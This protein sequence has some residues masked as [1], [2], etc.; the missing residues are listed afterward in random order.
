[1]EGFA[2]EHGLAVEQASI[3]RRTVVLAGTVAQMSGAFRVDLGRYQVGESSY[4][5][6]EGHVHVPVGLAPLVEGVF[7][8]DDRQLIK[9]PPQRQ[10]DGGLVGEGI[11]PPYVAQLYNFPVGVNATG[12]CIGLLEFE[13]GY[14]WAD[15]H[16]WFDAL[17]LPRPTLVDVSVDG[18][19]NSPGINPGYDIGCIAD[20]DVA[21]SVA[22]R[23]RIAVYFAPSTEQGI[24]DAITTAINDGVNSPSVIVFPEGLAELYWSGDVVNAMHTA[25]AEAATM[26][27]NVLSSAGYMGSDCGVGNGLAHV[28]FPASDPLVLSCGGTTLNVSA[29][30]AEET[31]FSREYGASG[32]GV[33]DLFPLPAFQAS[34]G[35]PLSVNDFHSGRGVPDV[36]GNDDPASGYAFIMDGQPVGYVGGNTPTMYA[37]LLALI[38]EYLGQ[39]VGWLSPVLYQA[40]SLPGFRDITCCGTNAFAGVPGYSVGPGWDATTGLGRIDGTNLLQALPVQSMRQFL[41]NEQEQAQPGV[42]ATWTG[43]SNLSPPDDL[44]KVLA[45]AAHPDGRMHVVRA[46]LDNQLWHSEQ[47]QANPG[48]GASWTDWQPLTVP[49]DYALQVAM[50]AHP[51]SGRMHVVVADLDNVLW[52]IEQEQANPVAGASWTD[53]QLLK[54]YGDTA[55]QVAMAAHPDG[56]MHVVVAAPPPVTGFGLD[57]ALWHI[58]QEQANPMAGASWTDWQPLKNQEDTARKVAMAVHRDG[59]V[60]VVVTAPP[61]F[62]GFGFG[63]DGQLWHIEQELANPA[64]GASWTDWQPLTVPGDTAR[65]VAMAAHPDGRMHVVVADLNNVLWHIEQEQ[66]NPAAGASWANNNQWQLLNN[67]GDTALQ[68]AM[69]VHP[70]SGRMHAVVTGLDNQVWHSEQE[71]PLVGAAWTDW[72]VLSEPGNEATLVAVAAHPVSGRMHAVMAGQYGAHPL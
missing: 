71:S 6:R 7:G 2:D 18:A 52:H 44:G 48:E 8:L 53:W 14:N 9:L 4:R 10:A 17:Q 66:A 56:R 13:C 5:G 65:Q 16:A 32:G 28:M 29:G 22:Q 19:T 67:Q 36:A 63:L 41:H 31:L 23:A 49:G 15:I 54:G 39:P 26:G 11:T 30:V 42:N 27:L 50:A 40:G 47:E 38:N 45:M 35:V 62:P 34:A 21:G 61:P 69:A 12:Q 51:D 70:D 57:G 58:E 25:F 1:V 33:S 72:H 60:H 37:A 64:A 55:R 68:V 43:W 46:G 24:V 59:R 20:I 3:P